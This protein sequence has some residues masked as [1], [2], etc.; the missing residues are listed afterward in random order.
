MRK[1]PNVKISFFAFQDII[2]STT[3][4]LIL[5]TLILTFFINAEAVLGESESLEDLEEKLKK[6]EAKVAKT[7]SDIAQIQKLLAEWGDADPEELQKD[8]EKLIEDLARLQANINNL[9]ED[10]KESLQLASKLAA[11]QQKA[12]EL[13]QNIVKLK[14]SLA[15]MQRKAKEA[16]AANLLFPSLDRELVGKKLLLVVIGAGKYEIY[17]YSPTGRRDTRFTTYGGL[18]SALKAKGTSGDY[19]VV[20]F[21]R[22]SGIE[23]FLKLHGETVL[24]G[25]PSNLNIMGYRAVGWDVLDE[26]AVLFK[27]SE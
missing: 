1:K 8:I 5:I 20:L 4:I 13:E 2:T 17:E 11:E 18:E 14:E 26:D 16:A 21:V 6:I 23:D 7:E 10:Q 25:K 3:G 24:R 9:G 22:P 27:L 15:E 12:M 19:Q